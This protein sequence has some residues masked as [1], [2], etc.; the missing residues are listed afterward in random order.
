MYQIITNQYLVVTIYSE[1]L[2]E[3]ITE[4]H[5]AGLVILSITQL[6]GE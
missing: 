1:S 2:K 5:D 6:K 4:A 3:A